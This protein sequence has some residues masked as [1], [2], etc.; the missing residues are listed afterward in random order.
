[1]PEG[2]TAYGGQAVIE[3]VM[4]RGKKEFAVAIRKATGDIIVQKEALH[5]WSDRYPVFKLPLLRGVLALFESLILGIKVLAYSA[6]QAAGEEGE[7]LTPREVALTIAVAVGLAIFLF[8]IVP[9]GAAFFLEGK[10]SYF[11]Q[12]TFEGIVRIGVFLGYL[13][14]ITCIKDVQRVFEY[15]GAEHKV[16]H[17]WER[18]EELTVDNVRRHS[19]LHPRCGT[20]F[21]L[22][23]LIL[24][25]LLYSIF[26]SNNLLDR[27]FLRLLFLPVIAGVGYELLKLSGKYAQKGKWINILIAPGL[28]LQRLTTREPDDNQLEVAIRA[29]QAILPARS[30]MEN[31]S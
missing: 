31:A 25:V 24:T 8:I 23:V 5:S 19:T 6:N 16:I 28:W 3:G 1:M 9:T 12:N 14:A 29:L 17:T 7:E 20:A 11:W 21:M 4:M 13:L 2:R 18:E 26:S 22:I 27:V 15:H 30:K 10:V